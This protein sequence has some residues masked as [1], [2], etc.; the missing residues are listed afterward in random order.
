[1]HAVGKNEVEPHSG[2]V[3]AFGGGVHSSHGLGIVA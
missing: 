2:A 1:M 3:R